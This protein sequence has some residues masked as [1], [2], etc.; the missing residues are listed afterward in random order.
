MIYILQ[1]FFDK[2]Q[3]LENKNYE[4]SLLSGIAYID[5]GFR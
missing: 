4:V 3:K 1:I 5:A 2:Y